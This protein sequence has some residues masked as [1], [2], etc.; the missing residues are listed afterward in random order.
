MILRATTFPI[1]LPFVADVCSA[2]DGVT[3]GMS[4]SAGIGAM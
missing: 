4:M 1:D 2:M 3:V